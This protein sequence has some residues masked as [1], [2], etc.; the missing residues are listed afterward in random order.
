MFHVI[1]MIVL[2][3]F[4]WIPHQEYFFV[5]PMVTKYFFLEGRGLS[6]WIQLIS[7]GGRVAKTQKLL[8]NITNNSMI[9]LATRPLPGAVASFQQFIGGGLS[10]KDTRDWCLQQVVPWTNTHWCLQSN[11]AHS[12]WVWVVP[13][14]NIDCKDTGGPLHQHTMAGPAG[15]SWRSH[16]LK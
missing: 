8:G 13:N 9:S 5:G 16:K 15:N 1:Y 6:E 2:Q 10:H 12:W 3:V 14:K 4:S 7:W 11:T